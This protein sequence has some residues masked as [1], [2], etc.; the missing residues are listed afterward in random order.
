MQIA[1]TQK[2]R[3]IPNTNHILAFSKIF[4]LSF[5]SKEQ[6]LQKKDLKR[7]R[8]IPR[9]ALDERTPL[10]H[11]FKTIDLRNKYYENYCP[12]GE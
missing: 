2:I 12:G 9:D 8:E 5:F 10:C 6:S 11:I 3:K 1:S 4:F 7:A